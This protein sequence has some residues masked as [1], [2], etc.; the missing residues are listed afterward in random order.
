MIEIQAKTALVEPVF[1]QAADDTEYQLIRTAQEAAN[2]GNWIVGECASRWLAAYAKGRTD[3]QFGE[4]IGLS[5]TQVQQRRQ[6]WEAFGSTEYRYENLSWSHFR[7]A[8]QWD[9]AEECLLWA[10]QQA[11]TCKEMALWRK[12]KRGELSPGKCHARDTSEQNTEHDD[13][14]RRQDKPEG[15][16][17]HRSIDEP[18][19]QRESKPPVS[20]SKPAKTE[21]TPAHSQEPESLADPTTVVAMALRKIDELIGFVVTKGSEEER[22]ELL[23]HLQPVVEMLAPEPDEEP[24]AK[25]K[26]NKIQAGLAVANAVVNEWNMVDGV[27]HCRAVTPKRRQSIATRM[28]DPFWREHWREAIDKVS[29]LQS[30]QGKNDRNWVA[31]LDW[32]LRPDTVALVL[33]GKY[34]NWTT[35][36]LS[37]E[38]AR[39][40]RNADSFAVF[41]REAERQRRLRDASGG[42]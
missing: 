2:S 6:V 27:L 23:S 38:Q 21:S 36:K 7:D 37:S 10:D 8:L 22:A 25:G 12:A 15:R 18:R 33:E 1:V 5:R 41:E 14:M 29:S 20:E 13:S 28:K 40:Q 34:D 11:A 9:D 16:T 42:D 17:I 39:E 19:K 3:E 30:L 24:Q 31:D 35:G 4:L 26:P 32:F